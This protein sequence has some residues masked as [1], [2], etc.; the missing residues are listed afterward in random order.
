MRE[1][2]GA[3]AVMLFE[4]SELRNESAIIFINPERSNHL[5]KNIRIGDVKK[6]FDNK[7]EASILRYMDA[8]SGFSDFLR[9]NG[10]LVNM[11]CPVSDH[12]KLIGGII[13][14]GLVD[15]KGL[16]L[17]V[18]VLD[19]LLET[20]VLVLRNAQLIKNQD[21]IIQDRTKEIEKAKNLAEFSN[22]AKSEFLAGI[23]HE[24]RTPLNTVIGYSN[25]LLRDD[26][27]GKEPLSRR[28]SENLSIINRSGEH[29]LLLINN[30]LEL[31]RIEADQLKISLVVTHIGKLL[32]DIEEM[33][34]LTAREKGIKLIFNI[35]DNVP[36]TIKTDLAKL[37]QILINLVDN[38]IKFTP[39]GE[40]TVTVGLDKPMA[41]VKNRNLITLCFTVRDTG[42]GID[43]DEMDKLFKAF[44]QTQS[45]RTIQ[46]GTGLGLVISQ[47]FLNFMGGDI[48][49]D[50]QPGKGTVFVFNIQ[51]ECIKDP[52][53]LNDKSRRRQIRHLKEGQSGYRILVVDDMPISRELLGK[54]LRPLGFDVREAENGQVAVE[55]CKQFKPHL[56]WMDIRMPVMDGYEAT[57][58]IKSSPDGRHIKILALTANSFEEEHVKIFEAGCDD[59]LI[60]PFKE[61]DLLTMMATHLGLKWEYQDKKETTFK[62]VEAL[63]SAL[64]ALPREIVETL[65]NEALKAN[66]NA[67]NAV[68]DK[69]R[70]LNPTLAAELKRLADQF[71]FALITE[72]IREV[73]N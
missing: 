16:K 70:I 13:A 37:R 23:T 2:T 41:V 73:I 46:K 34:S 11:V 33:F 4:N 5:K 42:Q 63:N 31:S 43:A 44:S 72:M 9:K 60:K 26:A 24:L 15:N 69:I 20:V 45:G 71:N 28:Q 66:M 38:A 56:I 22:K 3:R 14:F 62:M 25:L 18:E 7:N 32:N 19:V 29:L 17:I 10:F 67:V 27:I 48:T 61:Y 51:V 53:A 6:L 50:S 21:L 57:R 49:V 55:Q 65:Y 8:P 39:T 68:I 12:R 35:A 47:K 58:H 52:H 54:L 36:A 40:V 59:F 30:V 1:L 64:E